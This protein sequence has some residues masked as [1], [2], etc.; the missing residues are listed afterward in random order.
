MANPIGTI[1]R[2]TLDDG[3]YSIWIRMDPGYPDNQLTDTEWTCV[4]STAS[5]NIGT[6][7][8]TDVIEDQLPEASKVIG[9]IPDTPAHTGSD[10]SIGDR[11]EIASDAILWDNGDVLGEITEIKTRGH[12]GISDAPMFGIQTATSGRTFWFFRR[13]FALL[14]D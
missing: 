14:E 4:W 1:R 6:R 5:G 10:C 9:Q 7:M 12:F 2:E 11:V 13:D 8:G 3:G